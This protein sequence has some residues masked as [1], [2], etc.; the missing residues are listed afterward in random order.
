MQVKRRLMLIVHDV[1]VHPF[2]GLVK[3]LSVSTRPKWA[4]VIHEATIPPLCN[5]DD[6]VLDALVD[7]DDR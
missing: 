5:A 3:A 2:I 4:E 1:F 6:K 7:R